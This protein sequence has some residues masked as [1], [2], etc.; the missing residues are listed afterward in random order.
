MFLSYKQFKSAA[1]HVSI[2]RYLCYM[3]TLN[4]K[5]QKEK[6]LCSPILGHLASTENEWLENDWRIIVQEYG[7]GLCEVRAG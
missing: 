3:V 2:T 4:V 1:L 5:K 6:I 7:R